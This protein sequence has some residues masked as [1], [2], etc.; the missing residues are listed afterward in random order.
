M[1]ERHAAWAHKLEAA[2]VPE[3]RAA[4]TGVLLALGPVVLPQPLLRHELEQHGL[5]LVGGRSKRHLMGGWNSQAKLPRR[6]GSAFIAGSV[7]LVET[8]DG[9][10]ALPALENL[11]KAGLGPGRADGWGR[12]VA[13]HGIH[14]ELSDLSKGAKHE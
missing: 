8:D 6:T 11:E 2:S 1:A 9:T 7:W 10:S 4:S 13:C 14:I 12:L 3:Q 5:K